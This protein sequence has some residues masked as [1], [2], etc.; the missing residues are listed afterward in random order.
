VAGAAGADGQDGVDGG[1]R[2]RYTVV[3][4][5]LRPLDGDGKVPV[6][7]NVAMDGV[8]D[9]EYVTGVTFNPDTCDVVVT[10]ETIGIPT[11]LKKTML[12]VA[13]GGNKTGGPHRVV[14]RVV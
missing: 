14:D 13:K 5:Y 9:I 4:P 6:V 11:S 2:A 3:G 10:T 7:Q 1:V 8:I 12:P